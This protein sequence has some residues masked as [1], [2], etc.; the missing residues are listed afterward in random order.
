MD[1]LNHA[2]KEPDTKETPGSEANQE[3]FPGDWQKVLTWS[4][5]SLGLSA[6]CIAA[7]I[8]FLGAGDSVRSL[9]KVGLGTIGGCILIVMA[10]WVVDSWRLAVLARAMGGMLPLRESIRIS[11]MGAFM[12]GV[13]PLD[14]GGEPLK[15]FFLRKWARMGAGQATAAVALAAI[16]HATTKFILWAL[17]PPVA[18]FLRVPLKVHS[19]ASGVVAIGLFFYFATILILGASVLWPASVVRLFMCFLS[20]PLVR[21]FIRP[22][23][24]KKVEAKV[25]HVAHDFREGIIALRSNGLLAVAAFALSVLHWA[26]LLS[27]P[28][29]LLWRLG[30]PLTWFQVLTLSLGVYLITA[31]TPTPGGSGGAEVGTALF[32]ASFLPTGVLG[33]FLI[34][35]R[36]VTFYFPVAVGGLLLGLETALWSFRREGK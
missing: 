18:V 11:V 15:I 1:S 27:V 24:R 22:E 9:L 13:T 30:A 8:R 36:A 21:R 35:W 5:V 23:M 20:L 31:Y 14:T 33:T 16:L 2:L 10:G 28:V 7:V 32:F 34:V 12:A 6:L 25:L 19:A 3:R 26:V 4:A 29:F 17:A